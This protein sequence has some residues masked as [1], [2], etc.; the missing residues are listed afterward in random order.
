MVTGRSG[1]CPGEAVHDGTIVKSDLAFKSDTSIILDHHRLFQYAWH[2]GGLNDDRLAVDQ[3]PASIR[4]VFAPKSGAW[5]TFSSHYMR[6]SYGDVVFFSSISAL[7][8]TAGQSNYGS[9]NLFVE[10]AAATLR[11]A[12]CPM[13]SVSWGAWSSIGMAK[14]RTNV[15]E[16][17]KRYG[18]GVIEPDIGL[19]YVQRILAEPSAVSIASPFDFSGGFW[20]DNPLLLEKPMPSHTR[21]GASSSAATIDDRVTATVAVLHRLVN[22]VLGGNVA[23][24]E[25][26]VG[27][28]LD[29]LGSI[30]LRDVISREFRI[31]LPSTL[32]YDHPTVS[33]IAQLIVSRTG[34]PGDALAASHR[35]QAEQMRTTR[36]KTGLQNRVV[37]IVSVQSSYPRAR[38]F[39][40]VVIGAADV[41]RAVPLGRWDVEAS[42]SID[43]MYARFGAFF[44]DV[45]IFDASLFKMS[46]AQGACIDPQQRMLLEGA[47]EVLHQAPAV[48]AHDSVAVAVGCMNFEFS[49]V[50]SDSSDEISSTS[51]TGTS[52]NFM[53]GRLSYHYALNGASL[54][55]DTACSS[56]LVGAHIGRTAILRGDSNA[57]LAGGINLLLSPVTML[58]V[59]KLLALSPEGRC[60]TFDVAANGYGRS[61]ACAIVAIA[62]METT[63]DATFMAVLVSSAINQ[64]G[65]SSSLTA[66]SGPSQTSLVQGAMRADD[67]ASTSILASSIHGTGTPLGDP[68]EMNA[69]VNAL[70]KRDTG[71][72]IQAFKSAGGHSEGAAGLSGLVS[73]LRATIQGSVS[74]IKHLIS[75]NPYVEQVLAQNGK[76]HHIPRGSAGLG[77]ARSGEGL[78]HTSSFGMSGTNATAIVGVSS[79]ISSFGTKCGL[80]Q[81]KSLWPTVQHRRVCRAQAGLG[82][83]L[84]HLVD[85]AWEVA[86]RSTTAM[87][88]AFMM[89]ASSYFTT[90]TACHPIIVEISTPSAR[91][92]AARD[93][94][95]FVSLVDGSI[96]VECTGGFTLSKGSIMMAR[97][98]IASAKR[99]FE[100]LPAG[101][102]E[103]PTGTPLAA[104]MGAE[105]APASNGCTASTD[106][107]HI[108]GS[109][110]FQVP[111]Q[112]ALSFHHL[113]SGQGSSVISFLHATGTAGVDPADRGS[114]SAY[115]GGI[116][117]FGMA[118]GFEKGSLVDER[119][120]SYV[121]AW[122]PR[123][124]LRTE[125]EQPPGPPCAVLDIGTASGLR[126][127]MPHG[128]SSINLCEL[129][130]TFDAQA[131]SVAQ[132]A[133][134]LLHSEMNRLIV[135]DRPS[136]NAEIDPQ[137][138][139]DIYEVICLVAWN[140][141]VSISPLIVSSDGET[142]SSVAVASVLRALSRTLL[143]ERRDLFAPTI[144]LLGEHSP[145]S[146]KSLEFML[147]ETGEYE[148]KLDGTRRY[149]R[150]L[151]QQTPTRC[152]PQAKQRT[153]AP[154]TVAVNGG[155]K[156]LGLEYVKWMAR[157]PLAKYAAVTSS[158]GYLQP[159]ILGKLLT[160]GCCVSVTLADSRH[161]EDSSEFLET[162]RE[163]YP[164]VDELVYAA[165]IS[166]NAPIGALDLAEHRNVHAT[167]LGCL[168]DAPVSKSELYLSSVAS[169]WSQTSG[170]YYCAANAA[171]DMHA[172]SRHNA[173]MR[174]LSLQLGPFADSGL[175][176]D[177]NSEF[178]G[179]G[180]R[181]YA[182]MEI[183]AIR[184]AAVTP[185][186]A[187]IDF[188][189]DRLTA[190]FSLRGPWKLLEL[191]TFSRSYD[192]AQ[193]LGYGDETTRLVPSLPPSSRMA[194]TLQDVRVLVTS[195]LH[196]VLG[197]HTTDKVD[198]SGEPG[199]DMDVDFAGIDS[200]TAVDVARTLSGQLNVDID[201]T[202]IYDYP[203]V[204]AMA[205]RIAN[206]L[207]VK[208]ALDVPSP[209]SQ[210]ADNVMGASPHLMMTSSLPHDKERQIRI[211]QTTDLPVVDS[212][213]Y[214]MGGSTENL[215]WDR[216]SLV[217]ADRWDADDPHRSMSAR[218]GGWLRNIQLFDASLFGISAM[219]AICMDPQQ[220]RLLESAL[221]VVSGHPPIDRES[222]VFVGIQHMEYKELL[223][224]HVGLSNSYT[225]ISSSFSIAAGRISFSLAYVGPA[226]S[227]DT[228]CSSA[229]VA[230][231]AASQ[232]VTSSQNSSSAHSISMMLSPDTSLAVRT[233]GM[234]SLDGRCK[235]LDRSADG[236]GRSE[237]CAS[238]MLSMSDLEGA[239]LLRATSVNQDGRSSSLTAPS[240]P[241]QLRL[242]RSSLH[243]AA[244]SAQDLHGL[245]LHGTGTSLGDP[246][247]VGALGNAF[248]EHTRT[249]QSGPGRPWLYAPKTAFGHAEPASGHVGS[250]VAHC[251]LHKRLVAPLLH[252]T[253]VNP[254]INR[255][256]L[257]RFAIGRQRSGA[258]RV[259]VSAATVGVS[260]FAFQGT[261]A[262]IILSAF[263]AFDGSGGAGN[264]V[265]LVR[266][267]FWV[268]PRLGPGMAARGAR[269]EVRLTSGTAGVISQHV[270]NMRC[271]VP[272][273]LL[274]GVSMQTGD[275]FEAASSQTAASAGVLAG[276]LVGSFTLVENGLAFDV[277]VEG[278]SGNLIISSG[279]S[280]FRR[281]TVYSC[282]WERPAE[283]G[284]Q[285][286]RPGRT[287]PASWS[288]LR[289]VFGRFGD[290]LDHMA[291]VGSIKISNGSNDGCHL[292][293][294]AP[295]AD[296]VLQVSAAFTDGP[297]STSQGVIRYPSSL[298][299][300]T[301]VS[302]TCCDA[303]WSVGV[304]RKMADDGSIEC[305]YSASTT[306]GYRHARGMLFKRSPTDRSIVYER[307]DNRTTMY[308]MHRHVSEPDQVG[309]K[310]TGTMPSLAGI[311]ISFD[312]TRRSY[313]IPA[314]DASIMD[315]QVLLQLMKEED[316]RNDVSVSVTSDGLRG[317]LPESN[318][319]SAA[320]PVDFVR[321]AYMEF[322]SSVHTCHLGT[323]RL[324]TELAERRMPAQAA[325][326]DLLAATPAPVSCNVFGGT[327]SIGQIVGV[328]LSHRAD[329]ITSVRCSGR[330]G[331]ITSGSIYSW[332]RGLVTI[333]KRD[334]LFSEDAASGV[335][336]ATQNQEL[337]LNDAATKEIN[338]FV[339]GVVRDTLVKGMRQSDLR[340]VVAP[341][342][343][344]LAAMFVRSMM[345][346]VASHV[347][348]SSIVATFMNIGQANYCLANA[349]VNHLS[350]VYRTQGLNVVSIEWGPWSVGMASDLRS[351]MLSFGLDMINARTGLLLLSA[352]VSGSRSLP[353]V[354]GAIAVREEAPSEQNERISDATAVVSIMFSTDGREPKPQA[355]LGHDAILDGVRKSLHEIIGHPIDDHES[356]MAA[357]L[358]SIGSVEVRN[359]IVDVLGVDVPP[360]VAFDHPSIAALAEFV[361]ERATPSKA[362]CGPMKTLSKVS[363]GKFEVETQERVFIGAISSRLPA[364]GGTASAISSASQLFCGDPV[365]GVPWNR[366]DIEQYFDPTGANPL[367]SYTR[368]GG[369]CEDVFMFDAELYGMSTQEARWL[370]PQTRMLLEDHLRHIDLP[371]HKKA[372]VES[373]VGVYV[374][375]MYHEY[376]S[377][378][379]R[380]GTSIPPPQAIIGNGAA[381]MAGRI[382]Y[383]YGT[384]GPSVCTDTACSSSLVSCHLASKSLR[385]NETTANAVSGVNLM[386]SP[387]T[388]SAICHLKALSAYGRCFTFSAEADGYGRS[389]A[390]IVLTLVAESGWT[391]DG[392]ESG[393]DG[394]SGGVANT[395]L[396]CELRASHINQDGRSSGLTAPNGPAQSSLLS[397]TRAK[398]GVASGEVVALSTHGTGTPLGD[399]IEVNALQ[400]A[401]SAGESMAL[402]SSKSCIGHSE[403]AAGLAGLLLAIDSLH[404]RRQM[405]VGHLR[406][407]NTFVSQSLQNWDVPHGLNRQPSSLAAA[408]LGAVS[409]CSS[410]G[411]SGINAH[412]LIGDREN[413]M[414]DPAHYETIANSE[415]PLV[416]VHL[417]HLHQLAVSANL[418]VG[419]WRSGV[420]GQVRFEA[421]QAYATAGDAGLLM[422]AECCRAAPAVLSQDESVA[423]V[424][425]KSIRIFLT[426][427]PILV[428]AVDPV[429]GRCIV[430]DGQ[431]VTWQGHMCGLEAQR[432]VGKAASSPHAGH[433]LQRAS[434]HF[435]YGHEATVT[436]SMG[437]AC[438]DGESASVSTTSLISIQQLFQVGGDS[439]GKGSERY[440]GFG[441]IEAIWLDGSNFCDSGA[442]IS[443]FDTDSARVVGANE[444][445]AGALEGLVAAAGRSSPANSQPFIYELEDLVDDQV[446]ENQS[447]PIVAV[448]IPRAPPGGAIQALVAQLIDATRDDP[449]DGIQLVDVGDDAIDGYVRGFAANAQLEPG[450]D[451]LNHPVAT[452]PPQST[453]KSQRLVQSMGHAR[454]DYS[455]GMEISGGTGAIPLAIATHHVL[456]VPMAI[457]LFSRTGALPSSLRVN[458]DS[459]IP[460]A[461]LSVVN[462]GVIVAIE[463]LDPSSAADAALFAEQSRGMMPLHTHLVH[464]SGAQKPASMLETTPGI[465]RAVAS[466]KVPALT[467]MMNAARPLASCVLFSS[468]SA[469]LGNKNNAAYAA[470][471]AALD[472]IAIEYADRGLNVHSVQWG[473]WASIGMAAAHARGATRAQSLAMG[474]LSVEEGLLAFSTI[475]KRE[476]LPP[477]HVVTPPIYWSNAAM[478]LPRA[479]EISADL[480]RHARDHATGRNDSRYILLSLQDQKDAHATGGVMNATVSTLLPMPPRDVSFE[481]VMEVI[482]TVLGFDTIELDVPLGRQGLESLTSIDLK[483]KLDELLGGGRVTVQDLMMET[484]EDFIQGA[485]GTDKFPSGNEDEITEAGG[486]SAERG[487][488]KGNRVISNGA[489]EFI[490]NTTTSVVA[491]LGAMSSKPKVQMRIF[492]LPWAGGVSENLYN[493]WNSLFPSCIEVWPLPIPG[494][495][496]RSSDEPLELVSELAGHLIE[497]LPLDDDVPYA[498]FGTCLGAIVGYEMIQML[499]RAGRRS[500]LLFFPA[501][502]SPPDV[503]SSVITEIYNP[504]K[505]LFSVLGLR[506]EQ[507]GL[508]DRVLERLRGWR[509]LPKDE[510]LYAFEAGHFAGIEEMKLSDALFDQVAPM[511]VN[512]IIMACRYDYLA[513]VNQPLSCPIVAFDGVEDNTIPK[514]Y[515]KGWQ[516]HTKAQ[517]TRILVESNHYFVASHYLQL[518]SACSDAC[519]RVLEGRRRGKDPHQGDQLTQDESHGD[520][521]ANALR[522][523]WIFLT[524]W[525]LLVVVVAV[526][527]SAAQF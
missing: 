60:R 239:S 223:V 203:S 70:G 74:C 306:A 396:P 508:R 262:N 343:T 5:Q 247:E 345:R 182:A 438:L 367:A 284:T 400:K 506:R 72:T 429:D 443:S 10:A 170:F 258:A 412:A 146:I 15:L 505:S 523:L 308:Q 59:C 63:S 375:C 411:M 229:L 44:D 282:R 517:F 340:S 108:I 501:A 275:I 47:F 326:D 433:E 265:S 97:S 221:R 224:S 339:V 299:G 291:C 436:I 179:L 215:F 406:T 121:E 216:V 158:R 305:D 335:L 241:S 285:G 126:M 466:G 419:A 249:R 314:R 417:R 491:S 157:L 435:L 489:G 462:S 497:T 410:F 487:H 144:H 62:A 486:S 188:D 415:A 127:M 25:P 350:G 153:S 159:G 194:T 217:P 160:R 189:V 199:T 386:L 101:G 120:Q 473:A 519:L 311:R 276:A 392:V 234:T 165:G 399:P 26:L 89:D 480:L 358:D 469:I 351:T 257:H 274:L 252:L 83:V 281:Q 381:Y 268:H 346:P 464:A 377:D 119:L 172:T 11:Q 439:L 416:R 296:C 143:V 242:L 180:V 117:G 76:A 524:V 301:L 451:L 100:R 238:V 37:G 355:A 65:R 484:P 426:D 353:A 369:F 357:G 428:S 437:I 362:N 315:P 68:I 441:S 166:I 526:A 181:P 20:T 379:P 16:N 163:A 90:G 43:G 210:P 365:R 34:E 457:H 391:R 380:T 161:S 398:G 118:V 479:A 278:S 104:L 124:P 131:A 202:L 383:T 209:D 39:D 401:Y 191:Q 213:V 454:L 522:S 96:R 503:Y 359:R 442:V 413:F 421:T 204:N 206:L 408:G 177:L 33:A 130:D 248:E 458:R 212:L 4:R 231:H 374:G 205:A 87:H 110:T 302:E 176:K 371:L 207:G 422:L 447:H 269:L 303:S 178:Q 92:K 187:H 424:V 245:V 341:K 73:A 280:S 93:L 116:T 260:A 360:T 48:M 102:P 482:K 472:S 86:D 236:Y 151:I 53:A 38:K 288:T 128:P 515:M 316:G 149:V 192:D 266:K 69:L 298:D 12:G 468:I 304:L 498:I 152:T 196:E 490:G 40:D 516:R 418:R 167:K 27:A 309:F 64:D 61:E 135:A 313:A 24:S 338:F 460:T 283:I 510:V 244:M 478:L 382:A 449:R 99:P 42:Y 77:N 32:I 253:E 452:T 106:S 527:S 162:L 361:Y 513:G 85:S 9:V 139:I 317:G 295:R 54:A 17:S 445:R 287:R 297:S 190:A 230:V 52:A 255:S 80:L 141:P 193:S 261:N 56:S 138:L 520:H 103:V 137:V 518:A 235:A 200:L 115:N 477:V 320:P 58:A 425:Q 348:F 13:H 3:R 394:R 272:F 465:A 509:S 113:V 175:A 432:S 81:S 55:I 29:S 409:G 336:G 214:K 476:A 45:T 344:G 427:S 504:N 28:G 307:L 467:K 461:Q 8:G 35:R 286:A 370:D 173:G 197:H 300:T 349:H 169:L 218:F 6:D 327:G 145:I 226:V 246:I 318:G 50:L 132:I 67:V 195:T 123:A 171:L 49:Q 232:Y 78:T 292:A 228:A 168:T 95:A 378:V 384:S 333:S 404:N 372:S 277:E 403:G 492:C 46:D 525:A 154:T 385:L 41:Q 329:S 174:C 129:G 233:A 208:G 407:L 259:T 79:P 376:L 142:A 494:R 107:A 397:I 319:P 237:C 18:L 387:S 388:T 75:M 111:I 240:G 227:V 264:S 493:H 2:S 324:D 222:G 481:D 414:A 323:T 455:A 470:A 133:C 91:V 312:S 337:P 134:M 325:A 109:E 82:T 23:P 140:K 105:S 463:R 328:W 186:S 289:R 330:S 431:K 184:M 495:G 310:E 164:Y 332:G 475:L 459:S 331:Y 483:S 485:L 405:D 521:S 267:R 271:I 500:P 423:C 125:G 114:L 363:D 270:V 14:S 368:F 251:I 256:G 147:C 71:P 448:G 84:I 395:H 356:F 148:L 279:I 155:T 36:T 512:D 225:S 19:F 471:N 453:R 366:W 420:G 393:A 112:T 150:R 136:S 7:I 434:K 273:T 474:M 446:P 347:T 496:R 321:S 440:L 254:H 185:L 502:V 402:L 499:E 156:G 30:E 250:H 122:V 31:E 352:I 322:G 430:L 219:E 334:Q 514:G 290:A 1:H 22:R 220:R 263:E 488:A 57:S 373:T 444:R 198:D 342:R 21:V 354:V 201:A 211:V 450:A 294:I 183:I 66:P 293:R 390:S 511:A 88:L 51:A 389:E 507:A 98:G 94:V 364:S 243:A 456:R